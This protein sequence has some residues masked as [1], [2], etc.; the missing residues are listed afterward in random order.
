[1]WSEKERVRDDFCAFMLN[2]ERGISES[3]CQWLEI[4]VN[5]AS[6]V[7]TTQVRPSLVGDVER[8]RGRGE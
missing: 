5:S 1:M 3:D 6:S 7:T 8:G 2:S 4:E